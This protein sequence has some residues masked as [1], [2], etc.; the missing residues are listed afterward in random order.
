LTDPLVTLRNL[1]ATFTGGGRPVNAVSGA[2]LDIA[3][4]E[5]LGVLGAS[6]SG[7]SV[8]LRALLGILPARRSR[9][10]GSMCVTGRDVLGHSEA[11]LARYRGGSAWRQCPRASC[12]ARSTRPGACW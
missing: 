1:T 5:V 4:G 7:K 8:T 10:A 6:G 2:D 11:E 12:S 9:I 3:T